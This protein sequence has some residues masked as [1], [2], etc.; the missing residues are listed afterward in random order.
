MYL[1]TIVNHQL[2]IE[3]PISEVKNSTTEKTT[4]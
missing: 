4:K 3:L 1:A 2:I